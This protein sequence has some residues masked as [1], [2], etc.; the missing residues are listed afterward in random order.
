MTGPPSPK[1][2]RTEE[3]KPTEVDEKIQKVLESVGKVE[4][5]LEKENEKQ[6]QE[7]LAIETKYNK[8]KRP[9]YVKRSKLFEEIPSFWKQV[10][11][12]FGEP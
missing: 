2:Q 12:A 4:E 10:V 6:A 9:T 3:P 8:A 5:E 1:R 7:I 11:R